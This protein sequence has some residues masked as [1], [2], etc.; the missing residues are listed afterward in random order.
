MRVANRMAALSSAEYCDNRLTTAFIEDGTLPQYLIRDQLIFE[1][2][3]NLPNGVHRPGFDAFDFRL[4]FGSDF[5][6]GI[7]T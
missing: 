6:C 3:E 1:V 2:S 4:S 5:Q 7:V